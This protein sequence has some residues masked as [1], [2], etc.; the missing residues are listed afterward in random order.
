MRPRHGLAPNEDLR[1]EAR[2]ERARHVVPLAALRNLKQRAAA[3]GCVS[4]NFTS[5]AASTA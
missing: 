4:L 2:P 3:L 1:A 5:S